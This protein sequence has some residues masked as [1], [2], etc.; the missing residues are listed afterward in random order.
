MIGVGKMHYYNICNINR[1]RMGIDGEGIRTLILVH[2][3]PLKCK[4]CINPFTWNGELN[5]KTMT[6]NE[7]YNQILIDR[8]YLLAT[9][10]GLTIGGGEPLLYPT[11][12]GE[13]RCLMEKEMTLY[14]ETSFSVPYD[15]IRISERYIDHFYVDIKTTDNEI[16]HGYTGGQLDIA[17]G[18]IEK[19]IKEYGADK[20]TAR[21]PIIP[22]YTDS[23]KQN[24]SKKMLE[25][26]GV[27]NFDLFKYRNPLE[28]S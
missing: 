18:N 28:N 4:Y 3:C 10:G 25:D 20:L 9:K 13:L 27:K 19:Y 16:Y 2:G 12:F 7:I 24:E 6:A 8:P 15:N 21:I 5:P 26:I 22:S 11:L 14:T 1:L 17:F 23:K